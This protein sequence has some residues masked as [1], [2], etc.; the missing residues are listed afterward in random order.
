MK[1]LLVTGISGF[2]GW[3]V[4]EHIQNEFELLGIYNKTKPNLQN[5]HLSPL[6]LTNEKLVQSFLDKIKPNAILHLAANSNPNKCEQDESSN[7]INV[8]ASLMLAKWCKSQNIPF[9]FTSTDLVFDGRNPP[10]TESSPTNPIMVYGKQKVEAE[11][12]ILATY[13]KAIIARMPLMFGMPTNGLGYMNA[14]V[15]NLKEGKQVFC[16][17]DEYRTTLSGSA[18]AAGLFLLL[19][20]N[21]GGIFHLGGKE[22]I[23]RFDFAI[24]MA[25]V[26]NLPKELIIPSLQKDVQMP[27]KRPAD[28]SFVSEKAFELGFEPGSVEDELN[29]MTRLFRI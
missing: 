22:R 2:L 20:K 23:S 13:P 10:Y 6:D 14:W 11:Q 1:K 28:V 5:V 9:L 17:T 3:Y 26:F 7:N 8:E 12:K 15:R 16:F 25:E 24:R 19:E 29:R 27:S 21:Q 18:A 4:A